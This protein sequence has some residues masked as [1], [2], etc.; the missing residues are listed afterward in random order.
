MRGEV[1]F[2]LSELTR[3]AEINTLSVLGEVA[4]EVRRVMDQS[5]AQTSHA[6]GSIVQQLE[7]D[8]EVAVSSATAT[9]KRATQMAMAEVRSRDVP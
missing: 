2:R 3:R 8:I 1:E 7:K 5:Q 9:S 4:G 6:I